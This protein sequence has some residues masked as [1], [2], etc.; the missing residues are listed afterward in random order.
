M[1]HL[2][3]HARSIPIT[4]YPVLFVYIISIRVIFCDDARRFSWLLFM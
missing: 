4:I 1:L 2:Y 3:H